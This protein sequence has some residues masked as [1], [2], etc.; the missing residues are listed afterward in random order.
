[1]RSTLEERTEI[2]RRLMDFAWRPLQELPE[3]ERRR[4]LEFAEREHA[5]GNA[6]LEARLKRAG[7]ARPYFARRK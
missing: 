7:L 2:F 5:L 4:R 6:A 3:D 1:M